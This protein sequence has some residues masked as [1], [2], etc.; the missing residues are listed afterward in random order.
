MT[1]VR[2]GTRSGQ[3]LEVRIP[4]LS[5]VSKVPCVFAAATAQFEE[6]IVDLPDLNLTCPKFW[7]HRQK[8]PSDQAGGPEA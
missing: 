5:A 3:C 4:A 7:G 2:N 1:E 8:Q 6:K